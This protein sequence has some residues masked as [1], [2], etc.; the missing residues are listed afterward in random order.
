MSN[1][2]KFY[3]IYQP[4]WNRFTISD[5]NWK[6]LISNLKLEEF[7]NDEWNAKFMLNE[8]VEDLNKKTKWNFSD[9]DV[10]QEFIKFYE[11]SF[12]TIQEQEEELD[13][14]WDDEFDSYEEEFQNNESWD[15][16]LRSLQNKEFEKVLYSFE[17]LKKASEQISNECAIIFCKWSEEWVV[18]MK[19]DIQDFWETLD[20]FS[21]IYKNE[22]SFFFIDVMNVL[23]SKNETLNIDGKQTKELIELWF[24][25]RVI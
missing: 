25:I 19:K 9:N 18:L 8:V 22:R 11:E 21:S 7:E 15:D 4:N 12:W 24:S 5:E 3:T 6:V 20:N 10:V 17:A 1:R 13:I 16:F 14:L 23:R 2:T